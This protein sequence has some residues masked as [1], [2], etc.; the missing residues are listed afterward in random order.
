MCIRDSPSCEAKRVAAM[1]DTSVFDDAVEVLKGSPADP[2]GYSDAHDDADGDE[3]LAT[4][5]ATES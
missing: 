5:I 4:E 2:P 3:S 1:G